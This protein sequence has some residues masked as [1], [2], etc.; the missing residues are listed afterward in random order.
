M[1]VEWSL[2]NFIFLKAINPD[3]F[4]HI[5]KAEKQAKLNLTNCGENMRKALEAFAD[6]VFKQYP[7]ARQYLGNGD[8]NDMMRVLIGRSLVQRLPA[9]EVICEE[10]GRKIRRKI[11][12]HDL[13]RQLGNRCHHY[14]AERVMPEISYQNIILGLKC[15]YAMFTQQFGVTAPAFDEGIMPIG[16]YYICKAVQPTDCSLSGCMQEYTCVELDFRSKVSYYVMIRQY[17]QRSMNDNFLVRNYSTYTE[18]LRSD[19]R[20]GIALGI[21]QITEPDRSGN[22]PFYLV[23]YKFSFNPQ[24]LTEGYLKKL[25]MS[26]RCRL[27]LDLIVTIASMHKADTPIYHRMLSYESIYICINGD[28]HTPYIAKFDFAKLQDNMTVITGVPNIAAAK[29]SKYLAPEWERTFASENPQWASVD[30]YALGVLLGDI[31]LG[32]IG[33]LPATEDELLDQD[34]PDEIIEAILSMTDDRPSA[35]FTLED[36]KLSFEVGGFGWN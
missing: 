10:N 35:R 13:I 18:L 23:A 24:P 36:A 25:S 12:G 2:G 7:D 26:Q 14:G 20:D 4:E 29:R 11:E 22:S 33:V 30:I 34:L 1:Q 3:I 17:Y 15:C 31:M 6:H 28:R 16:K 32:K 21:E 27:C 9:Y 5:S 19:I 8:L